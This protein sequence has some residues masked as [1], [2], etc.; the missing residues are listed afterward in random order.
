MSVVGIDFIEGE[1][2]QAKR[3]K[4]EVLKIAD[5]PTS[6]LVLGEKGLEKEK[7]V[8][9]I[10]EESKRK[11][12]LF[13]IINCAVDDQERLEKE[14]FGIAGERSSRGKVGRLEAVSKGTVVLED[15]EKLSQELQRKIWEFLE[16]GTFVRYRGT[17]K[18]KVGTRLLFTSSENLAKAAEEGKFL[19]PLYYRISTLLLRVPPLRERQGDIHYFAQKYL[20]QY[21]DKMKKEIHAISPKV[22]HCIDTYSWPG[23]LWEIRSAME[24]AVNMMQLDGQIT[25]EEL[26]E[27]IRLEEEE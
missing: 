1:S 4:Q 10:H 5:S 24:Y 3:M 11:D 8:R 20:Q 13:L 14:L 25:M 19:Y 15:V 26:P 12:Q 17:K 6:V 27:R 18:Y 21:A 9:A 16:N 22:Y 2:P 23:N 7:I